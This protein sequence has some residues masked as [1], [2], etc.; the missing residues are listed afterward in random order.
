M[1]ILLSR[2]L[3]IINDEKTD[4]IYYHIATVILVNFERIG[5]MS[6]IEIAELCAVSKSMISKFVRAIG[7]DDYKEFI[8]AAPFESK[9]YYDLN[10][11]KNIMDFMDNNSVHKYLKII[12]ADIEKFESSLDMK[13]IDELAQNL[14]S[15]KY[16]AA[17]GLLYSETAA[18]DLQTKLA[19]NKKNIV[20]NLN[21]I[22][23]DEYI[24]N[25][26]EDTLIII[27]SNSG[28]YIDKNRMTEGK[29]KKRCFSQTKAK[30]VLITSNRKM[31]EDSRVDL[32]IPIYYT[33]NIQT[34]RIIF[35]L[36]TDIITHRYRHFLRL[37]ETK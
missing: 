23:Q 1:N 36:I 26:G 15:Y 10:Y 12:Q 34:H 22:K 17:F 2:L 14:I 28:D 31:E 11:N 3:V 27:F 25:A 9:Y 18:L 20:T 16:V 30:V 35:Q 7:F 4:S 32:C 13:R 29:P 24:R 33:T 8:A 19:Y 5:T 6:I 37:I 21:A